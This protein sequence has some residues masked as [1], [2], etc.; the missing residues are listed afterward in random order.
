MK[1]W[2]LDVNVTEAQLCNCLVPLVPIAYQQ[3]LAT[4][5]I[6]GL[7][8]LLEA[9]RKLEFIYDVNESRKSTYGNTYSLANK[10]FDA[11]RPQTNIIQQIKVDTRPGK[12]K[13]TDKR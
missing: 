6:N 11:T 1:I 9:I 5:R 8:D 13:K 7:I 3:H 10:S 2:N 4:A 12:K